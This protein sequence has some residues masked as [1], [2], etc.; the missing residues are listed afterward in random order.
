MKLL[1]PLMKKAKEHNNGNEFGYFLEEYK[2]K[3]QLIEKN[4]N[5]MAIE[6][7]LQI[8]M[9]DESLIK[10]MLSLE[11]NEVQCNYHENCNAI[12]NLHEVNEE[13]EDEYEDSVLQEIEVIQLEVQSKE[14]VPSQVLSFAKP[15]SFHL[16]APAN[17]EE[18]QR[19]FD[20]GCF[21]IFSLPY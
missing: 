21:Q 6:D 16:S 9:T 5:L 18:L 10:E 4:P 13:I 1:F 20:F 3:T 19:M 17:V 11:Y 14:Y 2:R 8:E 7:S 12:A 15:S